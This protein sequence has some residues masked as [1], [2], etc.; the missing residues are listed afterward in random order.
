MK[1]KKNNDEPIQYYNNLRTDVL[2]LLPPNLSRILEAGCGEGYTGAE[3]K[4]RTGAEVIGIELFIDAALKAKTRLDNVITGDLEYIE[5]DYPDKYFDCILY[6]D[7]LEHLKNPE[8][9]LIKHRDKLGDNGF[10]IASIPNI[11][12]IRPVL[13]ILSD[14]LEYADAGILDRT[15]LRFFTLH[16]IKKMFSETGFEIIK[17]NENRNESLKFK[18]INLLSCNLLKKFSVFQYLILAKKKLSN[19]L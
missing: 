5:L 2:E 7:V 3:A 4:K 15:H 13:S 1:N 6:A 18:I 14:K 16:T 12:Y 9:V 11:Q 19:D 10:V 8:R 17:I